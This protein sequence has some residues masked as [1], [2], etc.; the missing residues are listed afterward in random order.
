[1]K[2]A[3]ERC[4]I[5][6]AD[7]DLAHGFILCVKC[8]T[9]ENAYFDRQ[10]RERHKVGGTSCGP[11]DEKLLNDP[12]VLTTRHGCGGGERVIRSTKPQS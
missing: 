11:Q 5:P 6:M 2:L 10:N 1:M 4:F 12:G 3:C 8:R 7:T 9:R